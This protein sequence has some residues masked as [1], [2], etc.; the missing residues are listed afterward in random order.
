LVSLLLG[1]CRL[2]PTSDI[3]REKI[4]NDIEQELRDHPGRFADRN[5]WPILILRYRF[6]VNYFWDVAA[7]RRWWADYQRRMITSPVR[8][9]VRAN[10]GG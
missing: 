1:D 9:T 8:A 10:G 6:S 4:S 3:S 2:S 7:W 5:S